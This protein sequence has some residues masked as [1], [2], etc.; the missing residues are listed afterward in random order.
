[1]D[2]V[3]QLKHLPSNERAIQ[4]ATYCGFDNISLVGDI[5]IGR[6]TVNQSNRNF[7]EI[8]H[9]D[10]TLSELNSGS[11]W[12]LKAKNDN[13]KRGLETNRVAMS[14]D[15][16]SDNMTK[17]KENIVKGYKWIES[18]DSIEI[19]YKL[20][21]MVESKRDIK[22][23]FHSKSVIITSNKTSEVLLNIKLFKN[24]EAD[25][26]TWTSSDVNN[27]IEITLEKLA[28]GMWNQLEVD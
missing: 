10:F 21:V 19:I 11:N 28:K 15:I 14:H 16:E 18:Y 22:V 13:F 6:I 20:P 23:I 7:R 12:L 25:E 8:I 26:C 1:M 27:E 2:E 3:G 5:F 17:M 24:I 4:L 9:K